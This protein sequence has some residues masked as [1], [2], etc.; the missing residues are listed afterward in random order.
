MTY[1][2]PISGQNLLFDYSG[3]IPVPIV[4]P[5]GKNYTGNPKSELGNNASKSGSGSTTTT[6]S[7]GNSS[8]TTTTNPS[9][10]SDSYYSQGARSTA[11]ATKP[12]EYNPFEQQQQI[13]REQADIQSQ[14]ATA[15]AAAQQALLAQRAQLNQQAES[16]RLS[17]I[18]AYNGRPTPQV[19]QVDPSGAADSSAARAAAFA[20]AKETAGQNAIAGLKSVRGQIEDQGLMGS[21][22]EAARTGAAIAGAG[23]AVGEAN[24][25]MLMADLTRADQLADRNYQGR[26]AQRGQDVTQR[27]QDLAAKQALLSLMMSGQTLY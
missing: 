21:S 12:F 7:R 25:D 27:G 3:K 8:T 11:G 5:W 6:D 2:T 14:Q 4:D 26:L 10:E 22:V 13:M 23:N 18:S 16:Q 9:Y 15:A 19:G 24:R 17:M 1:K 20:R